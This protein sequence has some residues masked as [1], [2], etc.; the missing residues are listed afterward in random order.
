MEMHLQN[1]ARV[2]GPDGSELGTLSRFVLDPLPEY[3]G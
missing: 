2:V 1:N 3:K